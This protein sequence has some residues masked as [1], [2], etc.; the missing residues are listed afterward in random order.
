VNEDTLSSNA[1]NR[2]PLASLIPPWTAESP[3]WELRV[4]EHRVF[5]DVSE[6]APVVIVRA[7][8][9]RPSGETTEEIL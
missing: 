6:E 2:K 8:R 4:R 5:Y 7:I 9:K 3:I 1:A